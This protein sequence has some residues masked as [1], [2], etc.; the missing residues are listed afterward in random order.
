MIKKNQTIVL[1][2]ETL[3]QLDEGCLT[4]LGTTKEALEAQLHIELAKR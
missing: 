1:V 3:E 2:G 4:N